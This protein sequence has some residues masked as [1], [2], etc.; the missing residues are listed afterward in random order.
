MWDDNNTGSVPRY[1]IRNAMRQR[2]VGNSV[3]G[4]EQWCGTPLHTARGALLNI[5]IQCR[6]FPTRFFP[7][8]AKRGC[9]NNLLRKTR[10]KKRGNK[11]QFLKLYITGYMYNRLYPIICHPP[12]GDVRARVI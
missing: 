6:D 9:D 1:E 12:K 2:R 5:A 4:N 7:N 3:E 10:E 8:R 11:M